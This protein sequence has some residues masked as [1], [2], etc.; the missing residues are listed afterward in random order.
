MGTTMRLAIAA[1][2][3]IVFLSIFVVGFG[4]GAA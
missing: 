3:N 4:F 2:S 1:K